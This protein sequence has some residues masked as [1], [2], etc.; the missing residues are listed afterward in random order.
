MFFKVLF[1]TKKMDIKSLIIQN[2]ENPEGL[3]KLYRNNKTGFSKA[4]TDAFAEIKETAA[5]AF[6]EHRLRYEQPAF[7][8]NADFYFLLIVSVFAILIA[9]LPAIL[10][11]EEEIFYP[12]NISFIVLPALTAWYAWKR[13]MPVKNI[14]LIAA[15][16]LASAIYINL[17]PSRHDS[18]V[19]ILACLHLPL[20]LWSVM[21]YSYVSDHPGSSRKRMRFLQF[22]GNLLIMTGLLIIAG[23]IFSGLTVGMFS[24]INI[25]IDEFYGYYIAI[26][27]LSVMPLLANWLVNNSPQ[28]VDRIAPVIARIFTPLVLI[29]LAI[30]LVTVMVTGKNPYQDREFLLLF[31]VMLIAVMAIIVFSLTEITPDSSKGF[32]VMLGILAVLAI[33][34]NSVALSAIIFRISEWGFTPNRTAV[35]GGNVLILFHLVMVSIQIFRTASFNRQVNDIEKAVA[36]FLPAYGIWAAIVAFVFP[37]IFR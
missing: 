10:N 33:A 8:I 32:L 7:K 26:P 2:I 31:N 19:F 28:L 6:W 18:D 23:V 5:A 4:F 35:L 37:L 15:V 13:K 14:V 29:T 24:L 22:N 1:K 21:G 20:F 36:S 27:G 25:Q 11:I 12:R 9:K 30:Y 3:E 34:V 16:F 17:I